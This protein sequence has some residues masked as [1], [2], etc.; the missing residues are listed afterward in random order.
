MF[1]H[2]ASQIALVVR[3]PLTQHGCQ[4]IEFRDRT[5]TYPS[6]LERVERA[7]AKLEHST[8]DSD[9]TAIPMGIDECDV[10]CDRG[11][12][13]WEQKVVTTLRFSIVHCWSATSLRNTLISANF[14]VVG[15][16]T[17]PRSLFDWAAQHRSVSGVVINNDFAT[18]GHRSAPNEDC[19]H[20]S[21]TEIGALLRQTRHGGSLL[22]HSP[23]ATEL[24]LHQTRKRL[25]LV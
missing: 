21:R 13:S 25:I 12:S 16:V 8:D 6:S 4:I 20:R 15:P 9:R 17:R 18:S 10:H 3:G 1:V 14:S 24:R 5:R 7:L 19:L 22:A 2:P 11:T 23:N